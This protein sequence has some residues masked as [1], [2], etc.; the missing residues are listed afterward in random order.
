[1]SDIVRK[2]GYIPDE[3]AEDY[4]NGIADRAPKDPGRRKP[5]TTKT[6]MRING[7]LVRIK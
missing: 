3:L 4:F 5:S 7:Q 6:Y 1:L 2:H